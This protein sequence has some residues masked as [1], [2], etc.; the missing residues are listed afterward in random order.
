MD[1]HSSKHLTQLNGMSPNQF[2]LVFSLQDGGGR[3]ME[4]Y[5]YMVEMLCR[6][7]M[8]TPWRDG[9]MDAVG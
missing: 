8:F 9:V 4:R 5:T 3:V 2:A 7:A 1:L 6:S